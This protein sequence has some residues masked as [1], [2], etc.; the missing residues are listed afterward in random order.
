MS[1]CPICDRMNNYNM[2]CPPMPPEP[3]PITKKQPYPVLFYKVLVPTSIGDETQ[4]PASV[5]LYR[6]V[7]L[8]YEINNHTYIYSSDGIP[9]F[10]PA[11]AGSIS[12]ATIT[13]AKNGTTVDTFT[14]N[15]AA[16]KTIDLVIPTKTSDL[17]NDSTFQTE[18]QVNAKINKTV[19]ADFTITNTPSTT[20]VTIDKTK[21]NILT[22]ATTSETATLPVASSTQAGVINSATFDAITANTSNIDALLNGSVAISGLPATPTQEELTNAWKAQTGRTTLVNRASIYDQSNSKIWTY[23]NNISS[24]LESP[25]G[26]TITVN[27]W[28]NTSLG[29][30]KGSTT[31]GQIF[32]ESDGTGSVNG[33]DTLNDTVT[34]NSNNITTLQSTVA[35]MPTITMTTTDPGEGQP[36]AANNFIAVYEA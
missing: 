6:N 2:A 28:T 25:A 10:L 17:T 29:V 13:I 34:N 26:G 35:N 33:W 16:N 15:Q 18:A 21:E 22:G 4:Y 8:Q 27:Q 30:V 24:W 3:L 12:D 5:G 32:A 7:L 1:D 20:A 14:L 11:S 23:Y 9:T 31:N 36:L 19:L